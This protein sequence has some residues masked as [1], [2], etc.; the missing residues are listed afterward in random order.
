MKKALAI[1]LFTTFQILAA[2]GVIMADDKQYGVLKQTLDNGVTVIIKENHSAPVA[3]CNFWVRA[4]AGDED[5]SEKG[6][7]HFLEHMMF[8]GTEKRGVGGIDRE[9]KE[10]G[11]YNNAFTSYD[12]TNYVIVLPSDEVNKALEIEYDALSASVFDPA[13]MDKE[14][15]VILD[16]LYKGLD[17][18]GQFLWQKLMGL[19]FDKYYKDPIIGYAAGLKDY[20]QKQLVDY[21]RKYYVPDNLVVVVAG[22][23][24]SAKT[25]DYI[26]Q[27]FGKMQSRKTGIFQGENS[28]AETGFKYKTYSGN[29][30]SRYMA[31]G[32][33]IP[34]ALSGDIP[35]LEILCRVLGGSESSVLYQVLKEDKQL[36]DDIDVD[37]FTGKY[38]G[39]FVVSATV[40]EGKYAEVL[41]TLFAELDKVRTNGIRM[42]DVNKVK[43][44]LIREKAKEDMKVENE[45]MDLGFYE[46]M[47]DYKLY[48]EYYDRVKRV[49]ETDLPDMME[50]YISPDK[51]G[52]VL[53]Y[54]EKKRLNSRN[55]RTRTP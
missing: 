5:A 3:A 53:Y 6:L 16:E 42:E 30:E 37:M 19:C 10:L 36:V 54:P 28:A 35:K 41:K 31:V 49:I 20:K 46:S 24:D 22:D 45:A 25:L 27:T 32:F 47:S 52:I 18:P 29:I 50:K 48:Y 43:S 51:A 44:D 8:K 14:R 9:L 7:S 12:N 2:K 33:R 40:R 4:G 26:K 55:S 1:I 34:D 17:N 23:V 11:G 13:E 39:L 38:G 21:Y 15:E